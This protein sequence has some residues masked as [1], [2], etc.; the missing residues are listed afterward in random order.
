[1]KFV[2]TALFGYTESTFSRGSISSKFKRCK[3]QQ[4]MFGTVLIFLITVSLILF[5]KVKVARIV[6]DK[7]TMKCSCRNLE[8]T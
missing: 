4:C 8:K 5:R 6:I 7:A 3:K 1:M 2:L